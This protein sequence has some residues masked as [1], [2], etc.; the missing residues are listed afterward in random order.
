MATSELAVCPRGLVIAL[1]ANLLKV[2]WLGDLFRF[3]IVTEGGLS[4]LSLHSYLFIPLIALLPL[5]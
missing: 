2:H 5:L 1:L 3:A 4:F